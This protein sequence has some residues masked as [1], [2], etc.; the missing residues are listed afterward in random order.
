MCSSYLQTDT[1]RQRQTD[2]VTDIQAERQTDRQSERQADRQT[3]KQSD[4]QAERE[5]RKGREQAGNAWACGLLALRT[6]KEREIRQ[7][8]RKEKEPGN[9]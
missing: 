5:R 1:D 2:I 7:K 8:E 9:L 3:V 4:R 6:K